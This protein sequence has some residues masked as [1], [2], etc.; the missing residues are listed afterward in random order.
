MGWFS[1]ELIPNEQADWIV[2]VHA[3]LPSA[4]T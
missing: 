2:E 1:T 3:L 4:G